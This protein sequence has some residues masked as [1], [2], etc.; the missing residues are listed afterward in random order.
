MEEFSIIYKILRI[1]QKSMDYDEVDV[2]LI[3]ASALGISQ[4]K[5][6]RMMKMLADNGYIEGVCIVNVDGASSII[7]L[8]NPMITLK[9]LEYLGENSLMKK[10]KDIAMGILSAAT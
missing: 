9:G 5:W 7:Q 6:I 3:S 8:N 1:L 4:N 10:A 2:R